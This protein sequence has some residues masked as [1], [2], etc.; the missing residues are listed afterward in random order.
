[1][2]PNSPARLR[3]CGTSWAAS[4]CICWQV[5]TRKDWPLPDYNG[6]VRSPKPRGEGSSPFTPASFSRVF[7]LRCLNKS[8]PSAGATNFAHP[9]TKALSCLAFLCVCHTCR[10]C[11]CASLCQAIFSHKPAHVLAGVCGSRSNQQRKT[12][13]EHPSSS[14]RNPDVVASLFSCA[15]LCTGTCDI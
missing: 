14:D 4:A 10:S 13:S 12:K 7:A 2:V 8:R 11:L 9:N 15:G 3:Q 6:A 5:W 1:L